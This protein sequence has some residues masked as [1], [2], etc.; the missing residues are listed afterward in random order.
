[1]SEI[2]VKVADFAVASGPAVLSTVGL[3][4]CVAIALFDADRRVGGL[5]HVLLPSE[6]MARDRD[7]HAKFP[8]SAV[9]LLV[10]RMRALGARPS[11]ITAKIAG[12]ASMFTNL[13]ASGGPAIGERNV[14][15]TRHALEAAGIPVVAQDVGGEHGR[16]IYFH[17]CDGRL[18]VRSL[19]KGD[20]VL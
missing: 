1:V 19:L 2:R 11:R 16:S 4:S 7:N 6:T 15:A 8:T 5:A 20:V 13:L 3:G 10:E 17:L 12:G 9:P 14:L 18:H